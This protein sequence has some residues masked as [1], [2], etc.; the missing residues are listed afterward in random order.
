MSKLMAKCPKTQKLFFTE[1]EFDPGILKN[2]TLNFIGKTTIMQCPHCLE[3][4]D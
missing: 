4:H 3:D 2:I 1:I